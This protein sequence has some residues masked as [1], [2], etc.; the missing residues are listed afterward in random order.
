MDEQLERS[1]TAL[2]RDIDAGESASWDVLLPQIY[3]QL[4][5]VARR[6]AGPD[7]DS[8]T[9]TPTALVHDAWVKL[10]GD[11]G[12]DF[13]DRE[14]FFAVA[15]VTM[16]R[17]LVDG[18]RRRQAAKRGG[19]R[20]RLTLSDVDDDRPGVDLVEL[21]DCLSELERLSPRQARIVELRFFAGLSVTEVA[22]CLS[23]SVGTVEADWRLARA[24]LGRRL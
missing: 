18:A 14:H 12:R 17:L 21:D 6:I 5:D 24:W 20:Q 8:A 13:A 9:I 2:L 19:D 23:V 3:G 10:A 22:R 1:L 11:G 7:A 15:A 16:R 4:K